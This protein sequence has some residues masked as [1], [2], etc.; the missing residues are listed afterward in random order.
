MWSRAGALLG[1]AGLLWPI[2]TLGGWD[3][4]PMP[5][6]RGQVK[7]ILTTVLAAAVFLYQHP[8]SDSPNDSSSSWAPCVSSGPYPLGPRLPSGVGGVSG[9]RA[10]AELLPDQQ[11]STTLGVA[12]AVL[13][14][15][16]ARISS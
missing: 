16:F 15:L 2:N 9:R 6:A 5:V 8:R 1:V 11:E 4:G 14:P 10:V 7:G 13:D 12:L 3:T